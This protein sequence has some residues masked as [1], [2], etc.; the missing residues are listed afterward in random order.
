MAM[1]PCVFVIEAIWYEEERKCAITI[2]N[3]S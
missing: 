1:R 3:L 2:S